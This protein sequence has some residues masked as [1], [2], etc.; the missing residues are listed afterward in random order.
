MYPSLLSN[1]LAAFYSTT[2]TYMLPLYKISKIYHCGS[3]KS[4]APPP[5]APPPSLCT[6]P[7]T[8][9]PPVQHHPMCNMPHLQHVPYAPPPYVLPPAHHSSL[10][11]I[12]LCAPTTPLFT[13]TPCAPFL[14]VHHPST[15]VGTPTR[16]VHDLE[17][18]VD[19][20]SV[21][22]KGRN[23]LTLYASRS[24]SG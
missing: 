18:D 23:T 24:S 17:L 3:K 20:T 6:I 8:P 11:N 5:W 22:R 13:T 21:L 9:P 16:R 1:L 15:T 2:R 19:Q 12:P 10:C 7:C 4:C 14:P